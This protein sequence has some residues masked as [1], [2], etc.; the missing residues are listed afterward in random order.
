[1]KKKICLALLLAAALTMSACGSD[2]AADTETTTAEDTA[3]ATEDADADDTDADTSSADTDA[4][5]DTES[6]YLSDYIASDYVTLGEYKGI[7]VTVES[8]QEEV[9]EDDIDSYIQSVLEADATLEEVTGRA[10][11]EGDTVNIDYVGKLDGVAFDGGTAE[12]YDLTI[13]SGTFIDGFEDGCI[14]MEIGETKD[15][16]ATFPDP[17][18][19]NPDLA[20]QVATFTVT[21]NSISVETV[22]ELT[23]DYV[24]GLGLN[25]VSTVEE[26]RDYV[27]DYL[28]ETYAT[29][30]T[31][32]VGDAVWEILKTTCEFKDMPEAFY[33]RMYDNYESRMTTYAGLYGVDIGTFVS[34][35]YGG[36]AD[37]YEQTLADLTTETAQCYMTM[38]AIAEAEGITVTDAEME[39]ELASD[40][41]NYGYTLEEYR[42]MLDEKEYRDYML[43]LK[44]YQFLGE[45]ADVT[46]S[47]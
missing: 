42:S 1:M 31:L 45:N 5:T 7:A 13:G 16:K 30:Y 4:D 44:V 28:A 47:E 3:D 23:D 6:S 11:E 22:P 38:A 17:Y 40:A 25:D 37:D 39:E 10:V 14:G 46:I 2:T 8:G 21:V 32:E 24:A 12:G 15:V 20:G 27:S 33:N 18:T 36:E 34:Y 35:F 43:Y 41:A 9:T 19:N 26:Y 29:N